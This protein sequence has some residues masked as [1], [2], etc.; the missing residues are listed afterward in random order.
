M[1]LRTETE[2]R[3]RSGWSGAGAC[4]FLASLAALLFVFLPVS[5][6]SRVRQGSAFD[7]S[8]WKS[9]V[10]RSRMIGAVKEDVLVV[11]VSRGSVRATL[12]PP[13]RESDSEDIYNLG[14]ASLTKEK[15]WFVVQYSDA[16]TFVRAFVRTG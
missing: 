9:Q 12:G 7:Q 13:E 2:A 4:F 11:G 14:D 15:Q 6:L 3:S 16:G 5:L 1:S 8:Q 10:N